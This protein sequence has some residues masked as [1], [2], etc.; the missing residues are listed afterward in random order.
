MHGIARTEVRLKGSKDRPWAEAECAI[1]MLVWLCTPSVPTRPRCCVSRWEAVTALLRSRFLSAPGQCRICR[2]HNLF[3]VNPDNSRPNVAVSLVLRPQL[4]RI[5]GLVFFL[6]TVDKTIYFFCD[7]TMP[8]STWRKWRSILTQ[9]TNWR[10]FLR[11]GPI[12]KCLLPWM[13]IKLV[14]YW[15][16]IF[17]G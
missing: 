8:P 10:S 14:I 4:F 16:N 5:G 11:I 17:T 13:K 9:H 12:A 7:G 15:L 1:R 2:Q 6:Q 3:F